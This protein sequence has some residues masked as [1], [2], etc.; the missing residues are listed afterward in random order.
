MF[1]S[2]VGPICRE[3][4]LGGVRV[5]FAKIFQRRSPEFLCLNVKYLNQTI[6]FAT[7]VFIKNEPLTVELGLTFE[8]V[9]PAMAAICEVA[10]TEKTGLIAVDLKTDRVIAFLVA[11]DF[12]TPLTVDLPPRLEPIFD[13]L[14]RMDEDLMKKHAVQ[15]GEIC[16]VF[17]LG[18][19]S[20]HVKSN[21]WLKS[22][23]KGQLALRLVREAERH[24]RLLGYRKYY[25]QCTNRGSQRVV[26]F[27]ANEVVSEIDYS[28]Y[29]FQK[30]GERVFN[31]I[32]GEKCIAYLVNT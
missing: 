26:S 4:F 9:R 7:R 6:D 30:T 29:V 31:G 21:R 12:T 5:G 14:G 19:S 32:Q 8:D 1:T 28:Q 24:G 22:L 17:I 2:L 16:H 11:K 23:R 10:L 3:T 20:S 25:S 27:F 13:L 15:K 18:A